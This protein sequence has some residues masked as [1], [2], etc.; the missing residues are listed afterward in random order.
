MSLKHHG[1]H[2]FNV[3]LKVHMIQC[4]ICA[5][6]YVWIYIHIC[7]IFIYLLHSRQI[8]LNLLKL[9]Q[10]LRIRFKLSNYLWLLHNVFLEDKL[11]Q[12]EKGYFDAVSTHLHTPFYKCSRNFQSPWLWTC[13]NGYFS[14][15][16]PAF[17][18]SSS[19]NSGNTNP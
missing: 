13:K 9:V 15:P 19:L 3:H 1:K 6:L 18:N 12:K 2:C 8:Q 16:S 5:C 7:L 11:T 10:N 14:T 4:D 17:K